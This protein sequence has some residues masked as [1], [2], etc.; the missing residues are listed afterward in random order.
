MVDCYGCNRCNLEA[1]FHN[2]VLSGCAQVSFPHAEP[3]PLHTVL[4][5][6][7][8][9]AITLLSAMLSYDPAQRPSPASA[10][11]DPYFLTD[12]MPAEPAEIVGLMRR[13]RADMLT[14]ERM[15]KDELLCA[16]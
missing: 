15:L 8:P 13:T 10:L 11:R 4:P 1:A 7:S 14:A 9:A 2:A 16:P 5:H 12:P 3:T 6:A